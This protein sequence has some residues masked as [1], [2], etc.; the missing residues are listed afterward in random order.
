MLIGLADE[1]HDETVLART[2]GTARTMDVV[3]TIGRRIKMHDAGNLV[4]VDAAGCDVR[5]H[6]DRHAARGEGAQCALAL[7]LRATTV[8]VG[9][10]NARLCQLLGKAIDAMPRAAER[11]HGA[12]AQHEVDQDL[13]AIIGLDLPEQVVDVADRVGL[14]FDLMTHRVVLVLTSNLLDLAVKR[15]GEEQRLT[16]RL[17]LIEDATDDGQEAHVGHAVGLVD[18]DDADIAEVDVATLDQILEPAGAGDEDVNATTKRVDLRAVAS[19]AVDGSDLTATGF[20]ERLHLAADLIGK[21][22]GWRKDEGGGTARLGGRHTSGNGEAESDRLAGARGGSASHVA[23]RD[24]VR[25][26]RSLDRERRLDSLARQHGCKVGGH[27]EVNKRTSHET[28]FEQRAC[29]R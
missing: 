16:I 4:D 18:H 5:R 22:A 19:A 6:E 29:S 24:C 23:T 9:C 17:S 2:A 8:E 20:G 15:G 3:G 28:P 1:R 27:A 21:L 13:E 10:A 7:G 12:A 11:D 25:N 14:G 26:G